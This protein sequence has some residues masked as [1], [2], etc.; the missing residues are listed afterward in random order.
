MNIKF[1]VITIDAVKRDELEASIVKIKKSSEELSKR[2]IL[3]PEI[4]RAPFTI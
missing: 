2:L 4:A 1:T 3:D